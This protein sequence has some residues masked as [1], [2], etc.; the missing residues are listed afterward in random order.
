MEQMTT[1]RKTYG[2]MKEEIKG[3]KASPFSYIIW[4]GVEITWKKPNVST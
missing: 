2:I 3:C 1:N 4:K